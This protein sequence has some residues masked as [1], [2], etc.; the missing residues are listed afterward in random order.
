MCRGGTGHIFTTPGRPTG[1]P[2]RRGARFVSE[3]RRV[4]SRA[5]APYAPRCVPGGFHERGNIFLRRVP[6]RES[7]IATA[8]LDK[9]CGR[10]YIRFGGR[11]QN[12]PARCDANW[13]MTGGVSSLEKLLR[14]ITPLEIGKSRISP[15]RLE[16]SRMNYLR[17]SDI[18]NSTYAL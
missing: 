8:M 13:K 18:K 12:R 14:K 5:C 3:K 16:N 2:M 4:L 6:A 15:Q 17:E 11:A 7:A 1:M 10:R 9:P